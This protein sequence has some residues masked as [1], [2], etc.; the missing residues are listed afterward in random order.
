MMDKALSNKD[1]LELVGYKAN[2]MTYS[3]LQQYDHIDD[4]LGE[5]K[6]LVLLYETSQN[7][8]HWVCVFKVNKNKI[9]HFDSYGLAPDDELKFVPENFRKVN[10]DKI[11]HLTYL[12]YNSKCQVIY[13]EYQLQAHMADVNTCGRWVATR[14]NYRMIPQQKFA[15]FF[16]E[17]DNPDEIVISLTKNI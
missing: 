17:Y 5:Y 13:N 16:L 8:G 1:I 14:I 12:L 11:P 4:V 9:E 15:K 7:F 3:Q 6:A 10:Y 2:L